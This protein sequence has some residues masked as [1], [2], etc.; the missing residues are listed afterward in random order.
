MFSLISALYDHPLNRDS[1]ARILGISWP[2]GTL[3]YPYLLRLL[4]TILKPTTGFA[5]RVSRSV[6]IGY[7][8]FQTAVQGGGING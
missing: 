2:W 6:D 5:S 3:N 4:K 1:T 8:H 7:D